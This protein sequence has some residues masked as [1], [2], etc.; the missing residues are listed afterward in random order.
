MKTESKP[1]RIPIEVA[2]DRKPPSSVE[3]ERGVLGAIML[4]SIVMDDVI[5]IIRPEDFHDTANE[6]LF[7]H[8][9]TMH[10]SGK[11]FDL[12]LFHE[13]LKQSGD[14]VA[15]GGMAYIHELFEAVTHAAHA[16]YYADLVRGKSILRSLISTGTNIIGQAITDG[17]DYRQVI[18]EAEAKILG[19]M[20]GRTSS[21]P[22]QVKVIINEAMERLS[23]R[24]NG[25]PAPTGVKTGLDGVDELTGGLHKSELIV[26]AGRPSM[27]K[28]S[29]AMNFA[30]EVSVHQNKCTLFISLEMSSR[31]FADKLLCSVSRINGHRLRNGTIGN[32]EL[33]SLIET[34]SR[35]NQ[36]PLYIEDAPTRTVSEIAAAARRIKRKE[37]ELSLLVIDYLQLIEPDSV[38]EQRHEQVAKITRRLKGLA[39]ELEIP[40]VV[41]AQLNRQTEGAKDNKPRLVH[42]RESGAIEQ[43]ADVVLFPH[44]EE[45]YLTGEAAACVKGQAQIIIAKQRHGP[46]GEVNVGWERDYTRFTNAKPSNY[47]PGFDQPETEDE[48]F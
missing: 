15:V 6:K 22:K 31:E 29:L 38:K 3:A 20:D 16:T 5:G 4:D 48:E 8:M 19:V 40:V 37:G 46:V 2:L 18:S 24:L 39:R 28:S 26:I 25:T 11:R 12:M 7:R 35:I 36:S 32:A 27:G 9:V 42:L 47:T 43:D 44:R 41:L 17:A 33:N 1:K 23:E 45:Y 30:E 14:L 10:E 21:A 13:Q 34:A